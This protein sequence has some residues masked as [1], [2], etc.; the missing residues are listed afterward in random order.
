ML[1]LNIN[2]KAYMGSPMTLSHL[3]LG[4]LERSNPRSLRFRSHVFCEGA[5]LGHKLLLNI[6]RT[7][8]IESPMTSSHMTLSDLERSNSRSA[9]FRSL[10]SCKGARPYVTM[11]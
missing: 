5:E 6:N 11:K 3:T 1:L 7:A 2:G 9:R 10:I 8:Y 4:D